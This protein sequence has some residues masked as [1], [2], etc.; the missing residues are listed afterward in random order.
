MVFI[1]SDNFKN[2]LK[3][4]KLERK[5]DRIIDFYKLHKFV[6]DY[7]SKNSQY[8]KSSLIHVRT[9]LYTGEYTDALFKKIKDAIKETTG[10]EKTYFEEILQKTERKSVGQ[11]EFLNRTRTYYFFEIRKKPLQFSR[12]K[13]IFQKG[14]DVQLAVD[15]VT[16]AHLNTYDIAVLFSGDID[17]LESVKTVKNLGKH[18]IIFSHF[19]NMAKEMVRESDMFVDFQ[20]MDNDLL[21]QFSHIFEKKY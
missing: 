20:R 15:L 13:G 11:K 17:L 21:N 9:Y 18:V 10:A 7:L 6:I 5:Q 16:N 2:N 8:Q 1:D 14:V 19:K 4:I 12:D 3:Y